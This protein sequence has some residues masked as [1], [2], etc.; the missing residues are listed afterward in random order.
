MECHAR[1]SRDRERDDGSLVIMLLRRKAA[2]LMS[3]SLP[4]KPTQADG[5]VLAHKSN[6]IT[7][8]EQ[9]LRSEFEEMSALLTSSHKNV[10]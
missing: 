6:Q 10:L 9:P 4:G 2:S 8:L 1:R 5:D 3:L 7:I